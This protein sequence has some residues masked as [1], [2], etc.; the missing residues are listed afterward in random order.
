[1]DPTT[2]DTTQ[3]IA[4]LQRADFA[5]AEALRARGFEI[6]RGAAW[7]AALAVARL[8]A[9]RAAGAE[10]G[11]G[12]DIAAVARATG[13]P[14]TTVRRALETLAARGLVDFRPSPGDG[15]QR[16]VEPTP[17]FHI[18]MEDL[19]AEVDSCYRAAYAGGAHAAA[20]GAPSWANALLER[21]GDAALLTDAP[22]PG[23]QPVVLAANGAFER[24]TGYD[25]AEVIGRSPK[26]LQGAGTEASARAAIRRA[27]D[28]GDGAHAVFLNYRKN[29]EPYRC[30]L[31]LEPLHAPDGAHTHYLGIARDLDA[32]PRARA[33]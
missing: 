28:S 31:T 20:A 23:A 15:R 9:A 10:T 26:M 12:P 3:R 14:R 29:G 13:L 5:A 16:L 1:M 27:L 25:R 19:S 21:L 6:D 7:P 32:E 30:D 8:C 11:A 18:L 24:L 17:A 4:R 33:S 2:R 22:A